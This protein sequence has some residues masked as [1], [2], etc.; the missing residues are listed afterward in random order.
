VKLIDWIALVLI[1]CGGGLLLFTRPSAF[2]NAVSGGFL[3][4]TEILWYVQWFAFWVVVAGML[5][6]LPGARRIAW[7]GAAPVIAAGLCV[8]F[9]AVSMPEKSNRESW[10][11]GDLG[12]GIYVRTKRWR[13]AE[14]N[15][16]LV[17][18]LL[19]GNWTDAGTRRFRFE[20]EAVHAG[21]D[22]LSPST[23]ADFRVHYEM[24]Y[25]PEVLGEFYDA[26]V[27]VAVLF[28]SASGSAKRPVVRWSCPGRSGLVIALSSGLMIG[29]E[30]SGHQYRTLELRRG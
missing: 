14:Q 11:K 7:M 23:C 10:R 2:L 21:G 25:T 13:R 6:A 3:D 12:I 16:E 5:L 8:C 18:G 27:N 26:G 20:R 9:F 17:A 24:L 28:A 19:K 15:P 1:S 22:D 30:N 4:F 29:F